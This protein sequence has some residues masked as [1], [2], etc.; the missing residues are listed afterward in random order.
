M[1]IYWTSIVEYLFYAGLNNHLP[2]H[3]EML[4]DAK[5]T[6]RAYHQ[7][8]L[9]EANKRIRSKAESYL[10]G[11]EAKLSAYFPRLCQVLAIMNNPEMPFMSAKLVTDAFNLYRY[12]QQ[13]SI[14]AITSMKT[15]ADS[16]LPVDL[17][18]LYKMLPDEFTF[19]EASE[20][21]IRLGL[22]ERRFETSIR[23]KDFAPLFKKT[24]KGIYVK[25]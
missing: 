6:Y 22:N 9:G 5:D 4:S 10:I 20:V 11:A 13:S 3:I 2:I 8:I 24:G 21:C 23:K 16:G 15:E 19:K 1:G 18:N 25:L 17:D 7:L 14:S 12:F